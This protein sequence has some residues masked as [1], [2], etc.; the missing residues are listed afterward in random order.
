MRNPLSKALWSICLAVLGVGLV[1]LA[2]VL[3][4][5]AGKTIPTIIGIVG[6]ALAVICLFM[7]LW[8][9]FSAIGYARLKSGNGLITRWHVTAGD[10]DRFRAFDKIRTA[11]HSWLRNDMHIREQTPPQGVDVIV[12]RGNII[13]DGSY[14]SITGLDFQGREINWLNAPADPECIEFPKTYS[15][16]GG[17]DYYTLRVPVPASARAEGVRVFEHYHP[18]ANPVLNPTPARLRRD[19]VVT[20]VLSLFVVVVCGALLALVLGAPIPAFLVPDS[21]RIEKPPDN[22]AVSIVGSV[23]LLGFFIVTGL[24]GSITGLW[25]IIFRKRHGMLTKIMWAMLWLFFIG[26]TL[27]QLVYLWIKPA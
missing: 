27:L 23:V 26:G 24:V 18:K 1:L 11:E 5:Q 6:M 3:H 8:A 10:W 4:G 14:H 7:F 19:G 17:A 20:L 22:E 25:L 12:G 2:N 15:R 13:V 9:L 16:R 21:M